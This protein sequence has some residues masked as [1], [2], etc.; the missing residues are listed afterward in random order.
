MTKARG[1]DD[2]KRADRAWKY[3]WRTCRPSAGRS[4]G[5]YFYTQ[6]YMS[7]ATWQ[8]GDK[9][10]DK[11]FPD[12]QRHLRRLGRTV[13]FRRLE[14]FLRPVQVIFERPGPGGPCPQ[15]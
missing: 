9:Y 7:Q 11:Y 13:L 15:G 6:L 1:A 4:H 5:H 8:K 2:S 14:R 10:W 12:I 3:A